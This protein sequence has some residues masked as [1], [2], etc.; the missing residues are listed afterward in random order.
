MDVDRDPS[1]EEWVRLIGAR[2]AKAMV[3]TLFPIAT[4]TKDVGGALSA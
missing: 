4:A 1:D 2:S 3:S